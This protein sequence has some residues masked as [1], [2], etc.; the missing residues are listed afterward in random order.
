MV[1][2]GLSGN[3]LPNRLRSPIY[4]CA[5][6]P[7]TMLLLD[8]KNLSV[9][10]KASSRSAPIVDGL[11]FQL[12]KGR[13]LGVVGESGSGKSTAALA[14]IGLLSDGVLNA[15]G[16]AWFEDQELLGL[17]E[18]AF[19]KLQGKD[20]AM[21]FQDP[22]SSLNPVQ[23]IGD[24]IIECLLAHQNHTKAEAEA[25]AID[26]LKRVGMPA[27][28]TMMLRYPH[29]LSGGQRQRV[30]IAMAVVLKPKL[31]IADEPTTALDLTIQAQVLQ[32]L[33]QLSVELDLALIFITHDLG[34]VAEVSDEVI[35][36]YSGRSVEHGA[37]GD[38]LE[39]PCHPYTQG[40][41]AAHPSLEDDIDSFVPIPGQP[42]GPWQRPSGCAFRDRC[43]LALDIC[44][45]ETPE[46]VQ[47]GPGNHRASCFRAA[48]LATNELQS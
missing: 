27:P 21:V 31:L 34:V 10:L 33:K 25:L 20:I 45:Q 23:R 43:T 35:V 40:L 48:E 26:A 6:T 15:T 22:M 24:Q 19:R 16:E 28:H 32:L 14:I 30:M 1:V 4:Q 13:C 5:R 37:T 42:P 41:L 38:V 8:V 18:R 47:V 44:A 46:P 7:Q 3:T 9:H 2:A 29:Q 39:A 36:L 17:S 11:S 12:E